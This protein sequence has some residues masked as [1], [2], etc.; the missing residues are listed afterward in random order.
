MA[1]LARESAERVTRE[2]IEKAAKE[3]AEKAAKEI[4]EGTAKEAAEAAAK[5]AAERTATSAAKSAAQSQTVTI[6]K[7]VMKGALGLIG[8]MG[9]FIAYTQVT[10]KSPA[11]AAEDIPKEAAKETGGVFGAGIKGVAKGLG[12]EVDAEWLQ[13]AVIVVVVGGAAI[14]LGGKYLGGRNYYRY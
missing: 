2:A 9:G 8:G 6:S 1:A 13:Q 10:G 4:A 14:Y 7:T 12:L 11:Q 5:E 3:A